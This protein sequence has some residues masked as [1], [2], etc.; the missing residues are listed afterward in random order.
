MINEILQQVE[1]LRVN[2]GCKP[3]KER[4]IKETPLTINIDGRLYATAMIMAT[5][6]K[7]YVIGHLYAQ[8]VI[9]SAYAVESIEI[10]GNT[11]NVTLARSPRKP[12]F[13]SVHSGFTVNKQ[14][15]FNCVKAI[16][17]S[18]VFAE[19]EAVHSA[20]LFYKGKEVIGIAEDL[21]RHNALDKVIGC[22]VLQFTDFRYTLAASTGRI[23]TEM[24]FKCTQAKIP[25]I[26]TKGVPTS[27]AIEVA[28]KSGITIA[29]LVRG[30]TMIVYT[31]PE[32]I[33]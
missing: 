23:P 13:T 22:G 7:E 4:I 24:V 33:V 16:L 6:E 20:G 5:M 2:G 29:G 9:R 14:D 28:E 12:S 8:G 21:G 19:T 17:K 15:I 25:V 1:L 26:A 32:R 11:A 10:K 3:A 31:H 30:D 18:P 27:L